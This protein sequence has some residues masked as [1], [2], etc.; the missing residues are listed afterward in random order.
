MAQGAQIDVGIEEVGAVKKMLARAPL[1]NADRE[2]LLQ[3]V[4]QIVEEQSKERFETQQSPAGDTWKDLAEKTQAYYLR[5]GWT[6]RSLL[7]GEG[8]LRD[9]MTHDIKDGALAVLVGATMVYAA[10]HQFGFAKKKIPARPYLGI[11]Q[12]DARAVENAAAAFLGR[13]IR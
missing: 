7:V 13:I 10:V 12:D 5:R 9:S 11:S 4:G 3:D 1:S 2:R 8:L 6:G